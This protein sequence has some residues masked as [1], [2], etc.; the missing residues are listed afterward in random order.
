[1][2]LLTAIFLYSYFFK[3]E[4]IKVSTDVDNSSSRDLKLKYSLI[5]SQSFFAQGHSKY[6]SHTIF[7][8]VTDPIPSGSKQTVNT[9]LTLPP[10]LDLSITTCQIMKVD[11]IFKVFMSCSYF[12]IQVASLASNFKNKNTPLQQLRLYLVC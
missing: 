12:F 10:N 8:N 1:M 3:G 6:S 11:Y 7:K 4:L 5:Q 2:Q 9:D